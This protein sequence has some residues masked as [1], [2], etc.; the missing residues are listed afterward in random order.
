MLLDR[1]RRPM[2][3]FHIGHRCP[4]LAKHCIAPIEQG[5][6]ASKARGSCALRASRQQPM[7]HHLR[8]ETQRQKPPR[9]TLAAFAFAT[10]Y[11]GGELL[12]R[13]HVRE[14]L[15]RFRQERFHFFLIEFISLSDAVLDGNENQDRPFLHE[16]IL[17]KS[18]AGLSK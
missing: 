3:D 18:H 8:H 11:W 7:Q 5:G 1:Y 16:V 14:R 12:N 9:A 6:G 15:R 13:A 17:R 10:R 2:R 4:E